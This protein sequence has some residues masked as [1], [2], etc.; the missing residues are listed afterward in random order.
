N[1][2]AAALQG[3]IELRWIS[4]LAFVSAHALL[5]GALSPGE[6]VPQPSCRIRPR[7]TGCSYG[8]HIVASGHRFR[9]AVIG[10]KINPA[11][12]AEVQNSRVATMSRSKISA[13][14][15][16]YRKRSGPLQVLL[17]HLGGPFWMKKDAGAWF[18]PKG[19]IN[20]GEDQL[21]AAKREF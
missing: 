7:L 20:P 8:N 21:A 18:I 15:V 9:P 11:L 13:G 2:P 19:E 5:V 1:Y 14:L 12:A 17:V 6:S 16:M 3:Y 10:G 4:A